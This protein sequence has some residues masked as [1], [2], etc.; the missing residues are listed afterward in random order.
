MSE[1]DRILIADGTIVL[2]AQTLADGRVMAL[3]EHGGM[4][5]EHKGVNLPDSQVRV[6]PLTPKDIDDLRFGAKINVDYVAL[7]FVRRASDVEESRAILRGLGRHTPIIS[8]IEHPLAI[9]NLEEILAVSDGVMVARG[10]LGGGGL[11]RTCPIA[12]EAHHPSCQ[13]SRSSG[14]HRHPDARIHDR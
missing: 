9:E 5:G 8:K 4:L 13:R 7:S 6:E 14:N 10:D 12:S 3:V 2:R 1:G 11:A